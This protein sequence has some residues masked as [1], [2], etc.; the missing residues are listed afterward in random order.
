[1]EREKVLE[2]IFEKR[3]NFEVYKSNVCHLVK[4][5]GDLEFVLTIITTNQVQILWN[6]HWYPEALY[7]LGIV[8][9]LSRINDIPLYKMYSEMRCSKMKIMIYPADAILM[10]I[11]SKTNTHKEEALKNAIPE[12]LRH[13]I[14]E[15]D[16]RD[17]V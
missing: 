5:W 8:D 13:N 3:R 6:K 11:I 12:I 17:V 14:V 1:M 10:D 15:C 4:D 16:I 2:T 9:Y 7:L